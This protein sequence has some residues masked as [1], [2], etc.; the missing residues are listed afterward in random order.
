MTPEQKRYYAMETHRTGAILHHT[1]Y[2]MEMYGTRT[3]KGISP[4]GY[5]S[6]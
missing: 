4:S 6:L 2:W 5:Q 1:P 3:A